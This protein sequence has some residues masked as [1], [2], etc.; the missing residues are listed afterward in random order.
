VKRNEILKSCVAANAAIL[1]MLAIS[2]PGTDE[3]SNDRNKTPASPEAD[4]QKKN[5]QTYVDL[6]RKD[7]AEGRSSGAVMY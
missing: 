7:A 4:A 1:P 2:L 3:D 5:L 6:L